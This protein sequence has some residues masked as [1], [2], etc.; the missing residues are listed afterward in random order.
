MG[1][2]L[3]EAL[4]YFPELDLKPVP[5]KG[6]VEYTGP[7]PLCGGKDRFY[8][9]ENNEGKVQ[10][11]CRKDTH[12]KTRPDF[13]FVD[14]LLDML[15]K[16]TLD[17]SSETFTRSSV[18][19]PKPTAPKWSDLLDN[20]VD[21]SMDTV[22]EYH[23]NRAPALKY[24]SQYGISEQTFDKFNLGYAVHPPKCAIPAGFVI[25]NISFGPDGRI[26]LRS[27]QI[28]RDEEACR[29]LLLGR[30]QGWID[31]EK[32][33]LVDYWLK[34]IEEG[35]RTEVHWP[36]DDELVDYLYSKYT[37]ITGS[38]QGIWNDRLVTL[39]NQERIGPRL[40]YIFVT[41][42]AKSASILYQENYPA[43][44]YKPRNDWNEHLG[45]V[46]SQI[47]NVYIIADRDA[48]GQGKEI[49]EKI[50]AAVERGNRSR[51]IVMM[52]PRLNDVADFRRADGLY[53]MKNWIRGQIPGTVPLKELP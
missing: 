16:R 13:F 49:A 18:V 45:T 3:R 5:N 2:S 22:L 20:P 1:I 8:I 4:A 39:P 47:D 46:F 48:D 7:C 44:A 15:G 29:T 21:I 53:A 28:R 12:Q 23:S 32:N 24:F 25:P 19:P 52:T 27:V 42:D 37:S 34:R 30:A 51:A 9:F 38:Q 33:R 36:T 40:P 26:A 35:V 31:T 50:R 41:E 6:R 10:W 11:W 14:A 43:V 17:L